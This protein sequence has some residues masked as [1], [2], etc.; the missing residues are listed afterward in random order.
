MA[1]DRDPRGRPLSSRPRD[2]LGRPIA[3]RAPSAAGAGPAQRRETAPA[4]L[5]PDAALR[6]AQELL[7]AGRPFDAHEVFEEVWK[8]TTGQRR[9]L[10]RA[11]AQLCVG[12][13]HRLRGNEIG[14]TALLHRAADG[15]RPYAGSSPYGIAVDRIS[16]WARS[17][18][19]DPAATVPPRLVD[20][21]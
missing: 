6:A 4:A 17:A 14:A 9:D 15:L 19:D 2:E 3:R 10:W 1:R 5:D 7:D 18:G 21:T 16:A 12:V 8:Q 13:T 20:V 11:L